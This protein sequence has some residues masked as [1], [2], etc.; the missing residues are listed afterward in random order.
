[1]GNSFDLSKF[2][3]SPDAKRELKFSL[4]RRTAQASL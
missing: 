1:M 3:G 4:P 2:I